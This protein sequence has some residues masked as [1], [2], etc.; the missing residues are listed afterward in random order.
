M[1]R[2]YIIKNNYIDIIEDYINKSYIIEITR[3][4]N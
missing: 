3:T 2:L 1:N 4:L